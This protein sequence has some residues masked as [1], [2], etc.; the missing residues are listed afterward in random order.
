M[1]RLGRDGL[2]LVG[3]EIE[4][5]SLVNFFKCSKRIY[6][7]IS[8]NEYFWE[9]KAKK[10]YPLLVEYKKIKKKWKD[11]YLEII[12]WNSKIKK[13][14]DIPYIP[15]KGYNPK[16]FYL[17]NSNEDI[18]IILNKSMANAAKGGHM[19]IVKLMIEKGALGFDEAMVG[20]AE[21]GQ[22]DMV[23]FMLEKGA[24]RFGSAMYFSGTYG[25]LD[26]MKLMIEKG[27]SNF[28]STMITASSNGQINIVKF[29]IEKIF[30]TGLNSSN[31]FPLYI[32]EALYDARKNHH[33]EIVEL[34]K[35]ILSLYE[36][37]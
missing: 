17:T 30:E 21:K 20:A 2:F 34:L 35:N 4:S 25:H 15:T 28:F 31:D 8:K 18:D 23:K 22:Y 12:Y 14:F 16:S 26:I 19:D 5:D 3:M 27:A 32:E 29:I 9:C 11:L 10:D 37:R 36:K 1:E 7:K 13:E 24:T 33:T 6:E